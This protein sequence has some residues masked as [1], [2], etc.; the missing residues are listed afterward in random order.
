MKEFELTGSRAEGSPRSE[1]AAHLGRTPAHPGLTR[2]ARAQGCEAHPPERDG[3]WDPSL[4]PPS[5][6]SIPRD[7]SNAA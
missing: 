7:A 2:L 4:A 3:Q 1:S 5:V 6:R